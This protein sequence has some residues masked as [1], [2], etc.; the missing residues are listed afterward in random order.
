[1]TRFMGATGLWHFDAH[2]HNVLTDGERLFITDFGLASSARFE[3]S[4]AEVRFLEEHA[5]HDGCYVVT[6]LVNWVV[7]AMSEAGR[8][9][10][11]HPRVRN[12]FV[13]RCA[14]GQE[15]P[16]L[17]PQAAAIVRRYAPV[18]V[19]VNDFYFTLHGESRKTPYPKNE[20]D[21]ACA[22]IGFHPIS[23]ALL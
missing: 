16:E 23:R 21:R 4:G 22:V 18:A 15:I 3:L 2:F 6:E 1:M 7:T 13:R 11:A 19:V 8:Q 10:W 12:D 9:G 17:P 5:L 20:I 14:E